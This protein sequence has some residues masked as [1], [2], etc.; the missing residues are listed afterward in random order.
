[1]GLTAVWLLPAITQ[2]DLPDTPNLTAL[3]ERIV[4]YSTYPDI[5][6]NPLTHWR[7]I[8][9][10]NGYL[11]IFMVVAALSGVILWRDR[12]PAAALALAVAFGIFLS[13]GVNTPLY[14]KLDT[15][16]QW[17]PE[18]FLQPAALLLGILA[19]AGLQSLGRLSMV[20]PAT[21]GVLALAALVLI[22]ADLAPFLRSTQ[23]YG[24]LDLELRNVRTVAE[25]LSH[26]DPG[27]RLQVMAVRDWA[28][29]FL[30]SQVAGIDQTSG[31]NPEGSPHFSSISQLNRSLD[32]GNL[33]Y[34]VRTLAMWDSRYALIDPTSPVR[35]GLAEALKERGWR[36]V[37]L[38][39]SPT[40][41]LLKADTSSGRLQ[42]NPLTVATIG[43]GGGVAA[44]LSPNVAEGPGFSK[45]IEDQDYSYLRQFDTVLLFGYEWR[46]L[47]Q[48][49]AKLLGLLDGGATL[50][51]SLPASP[52]AVLLNGKAEGLD[53]SG[54]VTI[55]NAPGQRIVPEGGL[56]VGPFQYQGGPWT[57]AVITGGGEPVLVANINGQD[58]VVAAVTP[59][60]KGRILRVGLSLLTQASLSNDANARK[61]VQAL[62]GYNAAATTSPRPFPVQ[63]LLWGSEKVRFRYDSPT[64]A[65][66]L[67]SMTWFPGWRATIDGQPLN[68]YRHERLTLLALPAG[69]HLVELRYGFTPFQV[70]AGALSLA[71]L[72]AGAALLWATHLWSRR[73]RAQQKLDWA[74]SMFRT[75]DRLFGTPGSRGLGPGTQ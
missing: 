73:P 13:L 22:F 60:S 47:A 1:V 40:F 6:L 33:E 69:P 23:G 35:A 52:S 15:L 19:A 64:D 70:K 53:F 11:G 12:R 50:V 24:E 36:E 18:R 28:T 56:V 44:P 32:A 68:L 29:S 4:A 74:E 57:G 8:K 63:D 5:L 39:L 17:F 67:L 30:P 58:V 66:V 25:W 72:L 31:W 27:G 65:A 75:L 45:Y 16:Q 2:N 34:A 37:P 59:V 43:S 48:A 71:A 41:T 9:A 54:M 20:Q 38:H 21:R 62:L 7:D 55:R 42:Y 46:D 14:H 51:D 61:I 26:Q 3:P 49:E 10:Q